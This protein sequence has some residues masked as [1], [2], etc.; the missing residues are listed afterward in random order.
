ML[1]LKDDDVQKILTMPMTL[2]ALEETQNEIVRG[3]AATM[4]RIDLYLPCERPESYYRWAVM[5]GGAKRD[6]FVVARMLSDIVSWPGKEGDQRENKHCVQP[7]TYC[8]LLFMFS[9]ADGMP[10][11]LINDGFLQHMRVAGGAGMGVKYLARQDSR[12]VGM[13]GSGGMARSYLEAFACLRNITKVK[14]YSTKAE[15][16][17]QY[18][19]EMSQ[20]FGIEVQPVGSA[21]EAVKNVD[22]V[23]CCTSSIDPVFKTSWL[24]PG[25][26]VTD[27][28][29]DETE[30]GFA[31]AVDVAVK[32]GES[33]PHLENP[34]PGAF[35]AAHGFLGYVAGQPEEK[36]IIPRRPPREEILKMP[37]LADL[38]SGKAVGR[39]NERQTTWFLNL[40]VMGVQFAAVCT[41]VYKEAKKRGIG[42]EIPT[43]WFTQSIRD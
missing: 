15:N 23:A 7:G 8:G 13:I 33:T 27:V 28:T 14:V 34:P 3:N 19:K 21:R 5:T 9:V 26:H 17:K 37:T 20:K 43:E 38:I 30:P 32:M 40:G 42:G 39:T 11:A 2:E 25:M 1:L 10:A 35:Y 24:E 16:A 6:G 22:I 36:G 12:V 18:V 31:S 29:W 41:A 4:G